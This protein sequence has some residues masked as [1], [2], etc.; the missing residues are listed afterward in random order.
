[1]GGEVN[2]LWFG[3]T[4]LGAGV[5]ASFSPCVYPVIPLVVGYIGTNVKD[6]RDVLLYGGGFALG[7]SAVYTGLG[8]LAGMASVFLG[9]WAGNPYVYL[10]LAGVCFLGAFHYWHIIQIPGITFSHKVEEELNFLG[11]L[12]L[13][14]GA[15]VMASA[16][17]TPVVFTILSYIASHKVGPWL[18]GLFLL[19]FSLGM[20]LVYLVL[21]VIIGLFKLRPRSG[22]WMDKVYGVFAWILFGLGVYFVFK[23]GRLW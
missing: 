22:A 12:V 16:C 20:S 6:W 17:T 23:S 13:G 11:A 14:A 9:Q 2:L 1:M 4:C 19:L 7:L 8:L 21:A 15:G 5:L 18:G 10:V 3:L